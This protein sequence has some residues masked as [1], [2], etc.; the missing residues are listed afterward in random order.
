MLLFSIKG[1]EEGL[2]RMGEACEPT[3]PILSH[4]FCRFVFFVW[5][6]MYCH[7]EDLDLKET[8]AK[9]EQSETQT[10]TQQGSARSLPAPTL[11]LRN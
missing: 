5:R 8:E 3:K 4:A 6:S 9:A 11:S 1:T 7:L 10:Q 2:K